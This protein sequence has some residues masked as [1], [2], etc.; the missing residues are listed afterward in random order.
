MLLLLSTWSASA[1][2]QPHGLRSPENLCVKVNVERLTQSPGGGATGCKVGAEMDDSALAETAEGA[3]D[4]DIGKAGVVT[5]GKK[6]GVNCSVVGVDEGK[7]VGRDVG[8]EVG[9]AVDVDN[10]KADGEVVD[11]NSSFVGGDEGK[12][13]GGEE[14]GRA[15]DLDGE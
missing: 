14:V 8:E 1:I 7:A 3:V 2:N 15:V 12:S 13:N 9:Q 6:V 5:D 10:G 4:V 11:D